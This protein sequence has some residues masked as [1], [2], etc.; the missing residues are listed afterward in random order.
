MANHSTSKN[1]RK[2]QKLKESY[3]KARE[4]A[5]LYNLIPTTPEGAIRY[6]QVNPATQSEQKIPSLDRK[7][8]R[9]GWAVPEEAKVLI[10]D[11]LLEPFLEKPETEIDANGN[12]VEI[13]PDRYLLKENAKVLKDADRLQW[14][15]D[16]PED[17][18][19]AAGAAQV[20]IIPDLEA[21]MAAVARQRTCEVI[22]QR[23][24]NECPPGE[25]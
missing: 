19:K 16:N 13:E 4:E 10:V 22:E 12:R 21:I 6:E 11:R 25:I 15:R 5:Q 8:F 3:S 18:G 14:E 24:A 2:R 20:N 17:A 7:A 1:R 9:K 23:I